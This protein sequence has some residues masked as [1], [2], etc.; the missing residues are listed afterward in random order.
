[1]PGICVWIT[2]VTGM[3]LPVFMFAVIVQP[4]MSEPFTPVSSPPPA[5]ADAGRVL[6]LRG[7]QVPLVERRRAQ[8]GVEVEPV[9]RDGVAARGSGRVNAVALSSAFD[10]V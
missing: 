4:L 8:F 9:L 6:H 5:H 3:P 2:G 7:E 10:S 1:M